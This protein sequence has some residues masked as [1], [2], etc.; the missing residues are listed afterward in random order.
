MNGVYL[1]FIGIECFGGQGYMED[2]GIPV[3]LRDAQVNK[4]SHYANQ[5]NKKTYK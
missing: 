2:T 3:I 5:S 4:R 1:S